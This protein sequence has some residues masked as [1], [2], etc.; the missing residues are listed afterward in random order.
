MPG[1]K[2]AIIPAPFGPFP[3][4][5]LGN[6]TALVPICVLAQVMEFLYGKWP[7][8][9]HMQIHMPF[10]RA[11]AKYFRMGANETADITRKWQRVIEEETAGELSEEDLLQ[12]L[13][14]C[15][16]NAH[17]EETKTLLRAINAAMVYLDEPGIALGA[18]LAIASANSAASLRAIHGLLLLITNHNVDA[19]GFFPLLLGLLTT[20]RAREEAEELV[21][22][23]GTALSGEGL[24]LSTVRAVT[25]RL[26]ELALDVPITPAQKILECISRVLHRHKHALRRISGQ[27]VSEAFHLPEVDVLKDHPILGSAARAIKQGQFVQ[28]LKPADIAAQLNAV[29]NECNEN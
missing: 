3:F 6:C 1:C 2:P 16:K 11:T 7:C 23:C 27:S 21:F 20:E 17:L 26:A 5:A 15:R 9:K 24:S 25:K 28:C 13:E 10:T 12:D 19:P 18:M 29:Y 8:S 22:V 14:H 4:P